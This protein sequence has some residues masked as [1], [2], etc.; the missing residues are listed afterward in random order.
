MT[1]CKQLY[2]YIQYLDRIYD[3]YAPDAVVGYQQTVTEK[4]IDAQN[5][6]RRASFERN[7]LIQMM[8]DKVYDEIEDLLKEKKSDEV[9]E[10][11]TN[12]KRSKKVG[13]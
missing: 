4:A 7:R 3:C 11:K 10:K 5:Q 13:K 9:K 1:N 12:V 6:C 8:K 2:E